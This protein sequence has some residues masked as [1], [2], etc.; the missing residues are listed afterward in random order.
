MSVLSIGDPTLTH[1]L[2]AD[3][4]QVRRVFARELESDLACVNELAGLVQRYHGKMLRPMLVL[5]TAMALE[6]GAET[7]D[8]RFLVAAAVVEMVHVATL[9]HDDVL[10]EADMRRSGPTLNHLYGNEA[11][12]MLGDYLISHAYHLCSSLG[13][14]RVSRL[15]ARA[16]NTVCEG[17]LL[18]LSN[19]R[20]LELDEPTY[21]DIITRKTAS[22]CGA[23]CHVAAVLSGAKPEAGDA[24][25]QF[26]ETLG[27]AFQIVD[28][29]LDLTG[30]TDAVG[31]TLGLDLAKGK[32]TLPLIH[33]IGRSADSDKARLL[34][35]LRAQ[36]DPQLSEADR[37]A[38]AD[39]VRR[40]LE[41]GGSL[42]YARD[43][44]AS[45]V[46][47]AKGILVDTL[48]DTPARAYLVGLSERVLTRRK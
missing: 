20:N 23:C 5:T 26:G 43:T 46:E 24:L 28:D 44:A 4:Q 32:L 27:V 12:V 13:D 29:L 45:L 48:A 31:K 47:R 10:D 9:V 3:L 8:E 11:A 14:T 15:I 30:E 36:A 7:T 17:E 34:D 21:F 40:M 2:E 19:R 18:Q 41:Q 37:R 39:E 42:D 35:L 6:P 25:Y 33:A 38:G 22:L 16:T 1:R